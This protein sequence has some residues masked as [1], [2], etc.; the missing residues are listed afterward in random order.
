MSSV[1]D[2]EDVLKAAVFYELALNG[3]KNFKGDG[4][5][6]KQSLGSFVFAYIYGW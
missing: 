1:N 4:M 5:L 3:V 2:M 6:L